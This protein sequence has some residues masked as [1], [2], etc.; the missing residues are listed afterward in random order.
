[1]RPARREWLAL[2]AGQKRVQRAEYHEP[3]YEYGEDHM[4][5]PVRHYD[6]VYQPFPEMITLA[7]GRQVIVQDQKEKDAVLEADTAP[8]VD[9]VSSEFTTVTEFKRRP[10]RPK[11]IA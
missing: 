9:P 10:G 2:C 8:D 6:Y 5:H 7:D 11:K 4:P 3:Y 1:M